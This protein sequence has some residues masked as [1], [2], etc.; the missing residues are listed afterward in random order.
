MI[1]LTMN[2]KYKSV[3]NNFSITKY[4]TG[5]FGLW[6]KAGSIGHSAD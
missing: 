2:Y 1:I 3:K 5:D 6:L 4:S